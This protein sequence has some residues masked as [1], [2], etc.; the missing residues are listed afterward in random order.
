MNDETSSELVGILTRL[1]AGDRDARVHLHQIVYRNMRRIAGRILAESFSRLKN[2]HDVTSI[3]HDAWINLDKALDSVDLKTEADFL[4]FM[5]HKIRQVLLTFATR[6]R[7]IELNRRVSDSSS[8]DSSASSQDQPSDRSNDPPTLAEWTE[9]HE[10]VN[11]LPD[12]QRDIFAMHYYTE[13]PQSRIAELLGIPPKQVSRL[14]IAATESLA[15]D[16]FDDSTQ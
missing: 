12:M 4:R 9:F 13:I 2:H 1:R 10:R 15:E 3:V 8:A 5:A 14:W 6:A 11:L 7:P 16:F